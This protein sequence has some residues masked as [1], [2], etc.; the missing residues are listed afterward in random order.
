MPDADAREDQG[1][2]GPQWVVAVAVA[3]EASIEAKKTEMQPCTQATTE[4]VQRLSTVADMQD[5][6][7]CLH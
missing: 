6:F 1:F 7:P 3:L 4:A 2:P 5:G